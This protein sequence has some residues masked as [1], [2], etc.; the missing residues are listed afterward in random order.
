VYRLVA[1]L[2]AWLLYRTVSLAVPEL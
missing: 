1:D 2:H